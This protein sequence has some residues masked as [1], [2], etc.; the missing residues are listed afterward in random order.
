[1]RERERERERVCV[2]VCVVVGPI[3]QVLTAVSLSPALVYFDR[4]FL[5]EDF[6]G[7]CV[8]HEIGHNLGENLSLSLCL[9]L[10]HTH[11]YTH[12]LTHSHTLLLLACPFFVSLACTVLR[13]C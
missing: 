8:S 5:R 4:L 2:C 9:L 10:S 6:I 12:T 11:S 7:E 3:P 13:F 1:M